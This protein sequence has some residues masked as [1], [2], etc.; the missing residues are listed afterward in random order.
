M[1]FVWDSSIEGGIEIGDGR[2]KKL[3]K[4]GDD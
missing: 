4:R 1:D 2:V 3:S